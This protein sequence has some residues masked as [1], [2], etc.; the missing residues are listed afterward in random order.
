MDPLASERVWVSP[1]S[2]VQNNPIS[3]IDPSGASDEPV[4][5]SAGLPRG[6][7]E[8]GFTGQV[9]I[10]DGDK[11]FKN[12][13]K[14]ELLESTKNDQDKAV[15][16]DENRKNMSG[17]ARANI[18][19]HILSKLEGT[20]INGE[21]FSM[22]RLDDQKIG[23]GQ[24]YINEGRQANF[25]TEQGLYYPVISGLDKHTYE[26]TVENMQATLLIHEWYTHGIKEQGSFNNQ[27]YKAYQN[28]MAH[29][30]WEKTT[31]RYKIINVEKMANL[32]DSETGKALEGEWL[33]IYKK[34]CE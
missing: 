15:T 29:P 23:W 6:E 3:R 1:F 28:V 34:Y 24:Q 16:Y 30:F 13:T 8:E 18:W 4:Y 20:I 11:D 31:L 32:Y 10:Y 5:S 21:R 22:K 17:E 25:I 9:I 33:K 2:W 26:T 14:D 27:H 12:M 19:T 7:T